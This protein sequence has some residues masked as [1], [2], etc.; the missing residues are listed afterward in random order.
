M[1]M[2]SITLTNLDDERIKHIK[3]LDDWINEKFNFFKQFV[4]PFNNDDF[5]FNLFNPDIE[6]EL[7]AFC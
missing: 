2:L 5:I 3:E 6:P 7:P 1:L 4:H